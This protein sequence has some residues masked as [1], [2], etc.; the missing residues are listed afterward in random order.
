MIEAACRSI[1]GLSGYVGF[2]LLFPHDEPK[3]MRIVEINPRLT[4]SYLGYR[5]LC[6]ENIMERVLFPENFHEPMRWADRA[7]RFTPDGQVSFEDC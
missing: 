4:T 3:S 1:A 6:K 7:A 2:D 5:V